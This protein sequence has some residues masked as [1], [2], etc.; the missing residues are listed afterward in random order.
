ML[1]KVEK[2]VPNCNRCNNCTRCINC[3]KAWDEY[4]IQ[5]NLVTKLSKQ[6][7]R[8]NVLADLKTKSAKNDL[9]GIWKTIKTASNIST[10]NTQNNQ[11]KVS[12]EDMNIHFASIGAKL[13][14]EAP[15]HDNIE[16]S[17][18][19][20][21]N[22]TLFSFSSFDKVSSVDIEDYVK[23]LSNN[24]AIYDQ[25][26][27][28][29]FKSA[30]TFMLEPLTHIVNLSLS[31]GKYPTPYKYA[32]VSPI[33]KEGD[34]NDPSNYRPI[35]ILPF[36]GKCIEYFVNKQLTSY[37]EDNKLLTD[38]QY[39]FRKNNS[40]TYLMLDLFDEIYDS[41]LSN[42]KPAIIFLDVKKAFDT[43][44]HDILLKKLEFYGI[45]G[46]VLQWFRSYL[47][48]RFQCTKINNILSKVVEVVSGVP[49]G[50]ILGPILFSIYINDITHAC[51]LSKPFLFAD[52]G[53]L[54][55]RDVDR[56]H[57]INIK[58]ELMTIIKW[59]N[60]NKLSLHED[61][62]KFIVFDNPISDL[63]KKR[64][65][66]VG[67]KVKRK[68][69]YGTKK[70]CKVINSNV[71]KNKVKGKRTAKV[72]IDKSKN[73][74]P[75]LDKVDIPI[76]GGT[77]TINECKIKKYLGLMVDYKLSFNEHI[78]Y[79][80]KKV[81]KRIGAMYRSKSLLPIKYRK[82]FANALMIPQFDYLDIIY[83][84]A[85]RC[86]LKELDIIYKKVAKIALNVSTRESS[87]TVYKDMKWLPLH[88]RRQLHLSAYM[89]RI[90]N[91]Q[92]PSNFMNKFKFI[93]GGSRDGNNCNLYTNRSKTHKEFHYLGAKCWNILPQDLRNLTDVKTFSAAYKCRLLT[94]IVADQDYQ[95]NNGFDHFYSYKLDTP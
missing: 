41:K 76:N 24:K 66:K 37:M 73:N 13:Q 50:S 65:R 48:G 18:F 60:V 32:R 51:N 57:Y 43:V 86:K 40:T 39:G 89:Y 4:K 38:R 35:S 88:L 56:K 83:N 78:D 46:T 70:K 45:K 58:I 47:S 30:L 92:S 72:S 11:C 95:I 17:D 59:L 49:Q 29:I 67:V 75:L 21:S 36:V 3:N 80:I 82:M 79:I 55:F 87:I 1:H 20:P 15:I 42:C 90:I 8:Q 84:R 16:Y 62:T 5:R 28:R 27:L 68:T 93:S 33:Y 2:S 22:P 74:V 81:G 52:D 23:S 64:G 44:N 94:S 54:L 34:V 31:T 26:P 71:G 91:N 9:K 12:A 25:M 63:G 19:L 7:K 6:S 77:F 14:T 61:K 53:A 10:T 69:K 85:N